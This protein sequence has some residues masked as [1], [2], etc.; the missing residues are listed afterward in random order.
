MLRTA[1]QSLGGVRRQ[2]DCE[3]RTSEGLP[4]SRCPRIYAHA[5]G[6]SNQRPLTRL[7]KTSPR[8]RLDRLKPLAHSTKS[9]IFRIAL[10]LCSA[11]NIIPKLQYYCIDPGSGLAQTQVVGIDIGIES[12]FDLARQWRFLLPLTTLRSTNAQR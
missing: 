7:L 10:Y 9:V 4:L 3:R 2:S 11:K 12:D 1:F 8:F 5:K 6:D